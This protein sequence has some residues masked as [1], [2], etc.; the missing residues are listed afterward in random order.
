M[1]R[2]CD[3]SGHQR[4]PS[5]GSYDDR[6]GAGGGGEGTGFGSGY[7]VP[8]AELWE[9]SGFGGDYDRGRRFDRVDSGSTGTHG[10]HPMSAATGGGFGGDYGASSYGSG[11]SSRY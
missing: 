8:Q 4:R 6:Y 2:A 11:S 3:A 1:V 9:G 5:M 10:A 7:G